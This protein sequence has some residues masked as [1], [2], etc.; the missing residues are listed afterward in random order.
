VSQFLSSLLD[1]GVALF[2]VVIFG[3]V[4]WRRRKAYF[5][6]VSAVAIAFVVEALWLVV[7]PTTLRIPF[8]ITF[9]WLAPMLEEALRVAFLR[10][11]QLVTLTDWLLFGFGFGL[12]ES[13]V[14][15]LQ[16]GFLISQRPGL[17]PWLLLGAIV[18]LLLHAFLTLVAAKMLA[19]GRSAIVVLGVTTTLHV[20]HNWRAFEIMDETSNSTVAMMMLI[21]ATVVAILLAGVWWLLH[22][23]TTAPPHAKARP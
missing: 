14:K 3:R 22:R 2:V 19:S 23:V 7:N 9:I 10:R 1:L 17:P 4:A 21:Q 11:A 16:F 8:W 20:V 5:F 15:L 13:S 18:P 12:L 6:G